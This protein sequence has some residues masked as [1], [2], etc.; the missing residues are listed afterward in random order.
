MEFLEQ[1]LPAHRLRDNLAAL[2][3]LSDDWFQ[4]SL[5]AF[6]HGVIYPHPDGREFTAIEKHGVAGSLIRDA[7]LVGHGVDPEDARMAEE[8]VRQLRAQGPLAKL[9]DFG[10]DV[11]MRPDVQAGHPIIK[12]T[13]IETATI[14]G[15]GKTGM[16]PKEIAETLWVEEDRVEAALEFERALAAGL[17]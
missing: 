7:A 2:D 13:R 15:Y 12:G 10:E 14:E 1:G 9:R 16:S 11:D 3:A 17:A 6:K 5:T 4:G 8:V